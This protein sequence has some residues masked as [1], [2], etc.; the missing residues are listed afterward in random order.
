MKI[1]KPSTSV[2]LSLLAVEQYILENMGHRLT[3]VEMDKLLTNILWRVRDVRRGEGPRCSDVC[4][5]GGWSFPGV[6][7]PGIS[8]LTIRFDQ[9]L[10]A[11]AA[12]GTVLNVP[13][14][15]LLYQSCQWADSGPVHEIT[16]CPY[17]WCPVR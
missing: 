14:G 12:L 13:T 15:W 6:P 10:A 8:R 16:N 4:H 1:A 11:A 7:Y 3:Q 17:P 2:V 9:A 5:G